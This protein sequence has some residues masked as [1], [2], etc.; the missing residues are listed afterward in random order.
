MA[1]ARQ[2]RFITPEEYLESQRTAEVRS[3]YISGEVYEMSA[4]SKQHGEIIVNVGAELR[5][6]LRSGTC[7]AGSAIA[8]RTQAAYLIPD[9]VVYCDGGDFTDQREV[10][11]NPVVIFE[12]LSPSTADFDHG[13]KWMLYQQ[14]PSLMHYVLI[15]QAKPHVEVYSRDDDEWRNHGESE[16]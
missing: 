10:L 13:H 12:V 3:E 9:L 8:V 16:R 2:P 14:I 1:T 4:A 7:Q 6:G 11:N 5:S 15:S